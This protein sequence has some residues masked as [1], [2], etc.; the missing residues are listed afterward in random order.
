[1][2]SSERRSKLLVGEDD[3][4]ADSP[5]EEGDLFFESAIP[6]D[7]VATHPNRWVVLRQTDDGQVVVRAAEDLKRLLDGFELTE[8]DV[9]VFVRDPSVTYG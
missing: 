2:G 5:A 9:T 6:P 1:M 4:F 3:P 7:V 8:R